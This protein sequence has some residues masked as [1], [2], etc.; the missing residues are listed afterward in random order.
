M[1]K[2]QQNQLMKRTAVCTALFA[3]AAMA[4]MLY[5]SANK[6][7]V[8]TGVAQD[9]VVHNMET[10]SYEKTPESVQDRNKI[11]IDRTGQKKGNFCIPLPAEITAEDVT[12]ENHYM[13]KELWL[14]IRQN[15]EETD[16]E[17]FYREN[18]V[19]GQCEEVTGGY[20]EDTEEIFWLKFQLNGVYEY[21]SICEDNYLYIDFMTPREAY[22]KIVIIDPAYGGKVTGAISGDAKSKNITLEIARALKQKLDDTDIKV[23]YTRMSDVD[24]SEEERIELVNS[25]QADMLI[26]IEVNASTDKRTLGTE[27]VY[28]G[29]FFIPEFGNVQLADLLER[30]VVT[31]ISGKA[32]GL[33]EANE[34]DIVLSSSQ[35]PAATVR[36]GYL[37]NEKEAYLLCME[38]YTQ[39]IAEGI[40]RAILKAYDEYVQKPEM[41]E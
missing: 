30:E 8:V 29:R 25:V 31:A 28:N 39:K 19:S 40:Y 20:F 18:G 23:Y 7:V 6:V 2:M 17:A 22:D 16:C 36:A 5:Y 35:I 41:T 26:R 34:Q 27:T 33:T 4:V 3:A 10:A 12:I 24:L 14:N 37:T 38:G 32:N 21:S 1:I 15:K 9:E 13:D 11:T